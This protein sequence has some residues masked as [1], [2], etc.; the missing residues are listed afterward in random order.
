M[1]I[2]RRILQPAGY[3]VT[4]VPIGPLAMGVFSMTKPRLVVLDA[5]RAG[6]ASRDFCSGIRL[7]SQAVPLLILSDAGISNDPALMLNLGADGFIT[8][9]FNGYELLARVRTALRHQ[10][11]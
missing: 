10:R 9:P 1:V 2:L 11:S 8:K 4:T 6:D 3:D 7:K 5:S